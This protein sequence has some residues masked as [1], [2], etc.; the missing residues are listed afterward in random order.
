MDESFAYLSLHGASDELLSTTEGATARTKDSNGMF[1]KSSRESRELSTIIM[2]MRKIR[3][4][5]VATGRKDKFAARVYIFIIRATILERH[6]ESYQPALLHLLQ[7]I[8]PVAPLTADELNEFIGYYVLDLACRQGDMAAAYQIKF[9][10]M[11]DEKVID[12]ILKAL[13]HGRWSTFW[14]IEESMTLHQKRLVGLAVPGVR[15][16][17]LRCIGKSYLSLDKDTLEVATQRQW[18]KLKQEDQ[19]EW[20]LDGE[21]VIIRKLQKK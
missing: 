7:K 17:A 21:V 13:I 8:H 20:T 10:Y 3:E 12:L 2:A 9:I 15:Q 6:V 11:L 14:R 19:V 4:A 1:E 18:R 16:H 5:I